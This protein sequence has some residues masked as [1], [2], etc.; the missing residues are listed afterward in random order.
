MTDADKVRK[1]QLKNQKQEGWFG[2]HKGKAAETLENLEPG[3]E[4]AGEDVFGQE[5]CLVPP[6]HQDWTQLMF[7]F[8]DLR[9]YWKDKN[10]YYARKYQKLAD[11][12]R[13]MMYIAEKEWRT[14]FWQQVELKPEEDEEDAGA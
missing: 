12:C 11:H 7:H 8:S 3:E 5:I 4:S 1:E 6:T 14:K 13:E 9:D 2:E 10:S